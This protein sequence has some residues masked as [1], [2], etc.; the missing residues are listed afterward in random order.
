M[1]RAVGRFI[2]GLAGEGCCDCSCGDCSASGHSC[3]KPLFGPVEIWH[4]PPSASHQPHL[5][6][7]PQLSSV[8][9]A[10]QSRQLDHLVELVE[11]I[12]S[13]LLSERT[14]PVE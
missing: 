10:R 4:R 11:D 12:H 14:N 9:A 8:Q 6:H 2:A 13:R 7:T 1:I 5:H 3:T